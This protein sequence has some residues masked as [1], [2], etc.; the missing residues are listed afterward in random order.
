MNN[1]L[2]V[3]VRDSKQNLISEVCSLS[4]VKV[5]E[6]YNSFIEF[7]SR[8]QFRDDVVVL[9]VLKEFEDPHDMGVSLNSD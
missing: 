4:L 6:L 2:I 5:L 9:I 1:L 3:H 8:K 7:S